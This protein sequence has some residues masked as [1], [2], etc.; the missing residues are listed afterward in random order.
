MATRQGNTDGPT[1][2]AAPPTRARAQRG[3]P[4]AWQIMQPVRGQIRLAMCLAATAALLNLGSLLALALA[5]RQLAE[6]SGRWPVAPL[7]AAAACLVGGYGMRLSGFNQ[8]HAAAFRLE[9]LLRQQLAQHLTRVPLGEIQR[10]GAAALSKVLQDDVKALHV[11]VADSTPLYARAFVM[12]VCTGLALLWLDWRLALTTAAPLALGFGVLALAMRGGAEMGRRY[13]QAREQVSAAVIEFVQAMPVVRSFDTGQSTFGR[14]RQA[15]DGYL[16]VLTRWYRQAGFSA[17]VSFAVLNPLPTLLVLLWLGGWLLLRGQLAFGIWVGALLLSAGMAEAMMPMMMLRQMVEKAQLSAARIQDVLALPVQPVPA[18][19]ASVPAD[20][21]VVFDNVSFGYAQQTGSADGADEP[22]QE[23]ALSGV[24]FRVEPGTV[25]ALVG[26]SGAGKTTVARL[27]PRFWDVLEG[28]VSIGGV[29]V[30]ALPTEMLMAQ[31]GFVFQDTFLFADTVADN[32]RL[33]VP[34]ADMRA[35]IEAATAAQAHAF[36][37]ALPKDYDTPVGER[38]AALSGGQRQRIAVARAILQNRPILVLDEP[39]AFA[40]PENELALLTAL[41]ALMRGKTVIIVAHRLATVRDVDQILVF[42]R[43]RLV[44]S[45][46]HAALA[47]GG[48]VYARLWEH[49]AQARR[50]ALRGTD[51]AGQPADRAPQVVP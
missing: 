13:N 1:S 50:W 48:G 24:S 22:P 34:D 42:E 16:D 32:I 38:G 8:S 39:T 9:A 2:A 12:P 46:Q 10:W 43:G 20:A 41:A 4:H 3:E 31:V 11:F 19:C 23:R 26:P 37:Q 35:V 28:Q 51:A 33:G 36:I 45:G 29:D 18:A 47:A 40:D 30:R 7:L 27:I 49:H 44:E 25:T 14:Y 21:G 17:R 6:A 15:L 5:V